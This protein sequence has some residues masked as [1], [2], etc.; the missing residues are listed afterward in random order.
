MSRPLG[1]RE[2]SLPL[3]IPN[4]PKLEQGRI[5]SEASAPSPLPQYLNRGVSSLRLWLPFRVSPVRHHEAVRDPA[6]NRAVSSLPR[7]F[8]LQRI[9]ITR[10]HINPA[11]P[12]SPVELRPQG[13]APSRRLAP[14]ATFQAYFIPV[15]LLGFDPSRPY[16]SPGAVRPLERRAPQGSSSSNK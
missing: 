16:S 6:R 11:F 14:L 1:W 7:F 15:P 5:D 13:F 3:S 2:S 4:E 8:P 9:L 10:S 12:I